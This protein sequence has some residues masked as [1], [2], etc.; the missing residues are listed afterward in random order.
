MLKWIAAVAASVLATVISG[1]VTGWFGIGK[2]GQEAPEASPPT[3][4]ITAFNQLGSQA[5]QLP[6]AQIVVENQGDATA[7]R[8]IVYWESG[9]VFPNGNLRQQIPSP[10]FTLP[11]QQIFTVNLDSTVSWAEGGT[12]TAKAWVTCANA[13]SATIEKTVFVF[14]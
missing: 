11:G 1:L 3:I 5:G 12:V 2:D 9:I 10:E 14:A 4:R 8:C 13:K 6:L 7:E